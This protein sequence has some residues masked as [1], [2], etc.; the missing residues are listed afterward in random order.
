MQFAWHNEGGFL[1]CTWSASCGDLDHAV[2]QATQALARH[3][4]GKCLVDARAAAALRRN[5]EEFLLQQA[6]AK[7]RAA[8]LRC[9]ALVA[10]DSAMALRSFLRLR[11]RAQP[12]TT[13]EVFPDM[14]AARTWLSAQ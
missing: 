7:A 11:E 4:G 2:D 8:G 3:R 5:D 14:D 9:V 1:E 13:L 6:L 12:L 10:P